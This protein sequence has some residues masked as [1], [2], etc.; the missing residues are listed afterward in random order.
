MPHRKAVIVG[1]ALIGCALAARAADEGSRILWSFEKPDEIAPLITDHARAAAVANRG[2]TNGNK[3]LRIDF[4]PSEFPTVRFLAPSDQSW[5]WSQSAGLTVDVTNPGSESVTFFLRVD[6]DVASD[7]MEHCRTGQATIDTG[8]TKTFTIALARPD[9]MTLGMRGLPPLNNGGASMP[10]SGKGP[11]D[12]HHITGLHIFLIR[13]KE[14]R[15][16]IID[17]VRLEPP[18]QLSMTGIVDQFGQYAKADWPGKIKSPEQLKAVGHREAAELAAHPELP[19]RDPWG[20]WAKGPQ[21]KPTGFFRTERVDGKWWLVDPDGRLFLSVGPCTTHLGEATITTGRETMFQWLPAK[22]YPLAA[23]IGY[24]NRVHSGPLKEGATYDFYAANM[25]R[26]YGDDFTAAWTSATIDRLRAWGFNTLGNWSDPRLRAA[27]PAGH[28][29][30]YVV[31]ASVFGRHA[32]VRS[33]QDYWGAMHDPFDPKF[34]EDA[35]RSISAAAARVKDDPWCL[36]YF[37]DN[38]LSWGGGRDSDWRARYGL[39]YGALSLDA[40]A[41]PAKAAFIKQLKGKY[42]DIEKLNAAWG[43]AFKAWP[44]LSAPFSPTTA[45]PDAMR[46]DLT[47][48][49]KAFALKYFTIVRDAVRAADSNHL[50]LGCR[51]A[52]KT[53]EAVEA[54]GEICDVVAFNIYQRRLEAT[55]LGSAIAK[56]NKPCIIGEFHFGALDRGLFHPGLVAAKD[57]AERAAM[58][59][60]YVR[61][62]VDHPSFV[63]CHWFQYADEPLLGR[64]YDGENYNIGL[65]SVTDTPYPELIAAAKKA[66]AEMYER[67]AAH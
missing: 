52:W 46:Q 35:Q 62:V 50:Y 33:G 37:V 39:A 25:H 41:S 29:L 53:N 6:D 45:P 67:R 16:L 47:A 12:P 44:D 61:S 1:L 63:G 66:H 48:Y 49:L 2:V 38:E 30:A 27:N 4:Q 11:F 13:P 34:A 42:A 65:V 31:T 20:G 54:A 21:L 59:L 19:D 15:S 5:D 32:Q 57:Q 8:K 3:A 22:D 7:G 28:R 56:L 64:C 60:D 43:T 55:Q 17:N 40:A 58:Y 9:P 23:H 24:V 10:A 51:F 36:G 26:K 14:A 18:A